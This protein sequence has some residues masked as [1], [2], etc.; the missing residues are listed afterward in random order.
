MEEGAI[1]ELEFFRFTPV[2][3]S[4]GIPKLLDEGM[5]YTPFNDEIKKHLFEEVALNYV[6]PQWVNRVGGYDTEAV[7]LFNKNV[8]P[9]AGIK[10]NPDG[11]ASLAGN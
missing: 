9:V 10:I 4:L 1:Y 11:T 5:I 8:G 6:I 3:S 7:Q 2:L